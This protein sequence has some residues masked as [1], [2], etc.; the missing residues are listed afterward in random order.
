MHA[1]HDRN[2]EAYQLARLI[3]R[4]QCLRSSRKAIDPARVAQRAAH[5]L[6]TR[7]DTNELRLAAEVYQTLAFNGT[8]APR[9]VQDDDIQSALRTAQETMSPSS[10]RAWNFEGA[11]H[12]HNH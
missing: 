6:A 5:W 12:A 4:D 3:E 1:E 9:P 10:H 8:A 2:A 7:L 11:S